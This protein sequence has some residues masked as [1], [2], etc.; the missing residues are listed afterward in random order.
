MG[1]F[2]MPSLGADM[3]RGTIV[4][5]RVHPG[6]HV[7]RGQI[8]AVVETEKADIEIEVF[9]AGTFAEVLVPEGV[10]VAVG[11]PIALIAA[12]AAAPAAAAGTTAPAGEPAPAVATPVPHTRSPLVRH[13]A[14]TL[15]IDVAHL[16][17]SGPGGIVRRADVE[18]AA[19]PA[20]P[21]PAAPPAPPLH[22]RTAAAGRVD[23]VRP[24]ASPLAR[25]LAAARGIELDGVVAHHADGAVHAADVEH[26]AARAAAAGA[27]A[28]A[29]AGTT[30]AATATRAERLQQAIG[31]LMERSKREIPHFY[32][33]HEI[34]IEPALV[35]LE[36][37]NRDRPVAERVLPAALLLRA[38]V[39][40]AGAAPGLNGVHVD[41]RFEPSTRIDLGVAVAARGGGL[42]APVIPDAGSLGL[43][44]LMVAMRELVGRVRAGALR[45][46]DTAPGTITVTN[47]G[48]QGVDEVYGVIVPPQVAIVGFGAV[49]PRPLV[50]GDAVTVSRGVT[51]SLSADH[52]V[53]DG[54]RGSRFLRAVAAALADPEGL[55]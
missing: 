15:H 32:L 1:T 50:R 14:D 24:T 41:G 55:A 8:V 7:E 5:W 49:S 27:G 35:W 19:T 23:G 42:L 22:T 21:A 6:D 47:L 3:E 53:S 40:A 26:A 54:H 18:R 31:R 44:E 51:V 33:R 10:E 25:R 13:L 43:D 9:E 29:G 37:R 38:V 36:E 39:L 20:P 46:A 52:R 28:G 45:G 4:E 16:E 48:D 11:T 2:R 12:G 30:P 17:P 34:D